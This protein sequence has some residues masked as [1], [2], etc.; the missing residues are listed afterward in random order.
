[1]TT[2]FHIVMSQTL[3]GKQTEE[4]KDLWYL[5]QHTET[6]HLWTLQQRELPARHHFVSLIGILNEFCP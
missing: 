5:H 1:M 3:A 2:S 4:E 6:E